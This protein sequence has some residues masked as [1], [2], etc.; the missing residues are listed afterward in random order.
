[1][2]QAARRKNQKQLC[3][4]GLREHR[5]KPQIHYQYSDRP[6]QMLGFILYFLSVKPLR[7]LCPLWQ[8]VLFFSNPCFLP[9]YFSSI[10]DSWKGGT[11]V[12]MGTSITTGRFDSSPSTRAL[13]RSSGFALIPFAPNASVNLGK[14]GFLRSVP[15]ILP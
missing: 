13:S 14:S 4:R 6:F 2:P 5:E 11:S 7:A 1:M 3:H 15:T 12:G 9:F 8:M 10:E